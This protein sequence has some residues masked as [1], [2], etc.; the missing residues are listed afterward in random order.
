MNA[1]YYP[2]KRRLGGSKF[3]AREKLCR[4]WRPVPGCNMHK[5]I[6][7]ERRA[8]ILF[9]KYCFG[10]GTNYRTQA[11]A[12]LLYWRSHPKEWAAILAQ[13]DRK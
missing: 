1:S 6:V 13:V 7:G 2:M 11:R 3:T 12:T 9:E 10:I 5:E 4:H 8:K